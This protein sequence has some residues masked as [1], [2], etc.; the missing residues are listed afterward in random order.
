[1]N[2]L[3]VSH[4]YPHAS[5]PRL[6]VFVE[7]EV[8]ALSD[9]C[10]LR[11]LAPIP[12]TPPLWRARRWGAHASPPRHEI[13]HG[14]EISRPAIIVFPRR[15]LF[16]LLGFSYFVSLLAQVR[17]TD[18]SFGFDLIH[19]HTAYPDG[20]AAA[21]LG[22]VL[23]RPVVVTLHGSDITVNLER[24]LW[25]RLS[26]WGLSRANR[27][28]AVSQALR[29]KVV[30][31]YGAEGSGVTV[32]PNGVDVSRFVPIPA[33]EARD[34]LRLDTQR[35]I[36]LYVGA[37]KRSKGVDYLLRAARRLAE[38]HERRPRF[39]FLGAGDH[40]REAK[41]LADELG[42]R[43]SVVFVGN[44]PNT[45][46]PLWMNACDVLVLPS[47][48]EGFGVVLIE[49][50]ACG[51]PVIAT[52]CGG[53]EE[54]VNPDTGIL[55]PPR[56]EVAL[57]AALDDVLSRKRAFDPQRI[58]QH[59]IDNYAYNRIAPRI[60]EVYRQTLPGREPPR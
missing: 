18:N 6:G 55:V 42:L 48:S 53:P 16:S 3:V 47:L 8:K 54:I 31:K 52:R 4:M 2:V 43:E 30:D 24:Y 51:K 10:Q 5:D 44:R 59:A 12:W 46:I 60:M 41:L 9:L 32:I 21:L 57:S 40:E 37:I 23:H 34:A 15:I 29:R 27:V 25:R 7:E 35:P 50:M 28:I 45:E 22:R 13:R 19:A 33:V 39:F 14:I 11:V 38:T 49:A 58:R 36:V 26:L 1:M 56:D 17:D 20:F